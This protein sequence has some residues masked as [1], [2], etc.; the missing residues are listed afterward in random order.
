[1]AKGKQAEI[2]VQR[3]LASIGWTVLSCNYRRLGFEVD[4]LALKNEQLMGVE[5]KYRQN[6]DAKQASLNEIVTSS[7]ILR[8]SQ[9]M[10]QFECESNVHYRSKRIDLFV[11]SGGG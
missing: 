8:L 4:I 10:N 5:V 1:M 9:G 6:F 11:V 7:Q 2:L 3:Y